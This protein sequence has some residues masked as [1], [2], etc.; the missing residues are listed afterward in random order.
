MKRTALVTGVLGGIGRATAKA[1]NEAGWHVIGVDRREDERLPY[2]D[3]YIQAD[4]ASPGEIA[5]AVECGGRAAGRLD[6]LVNMAA[7]QICKPAVQM[8]VEEWD[9]TMAVN[10]RAAF[11]FSKG[12]HP[13]L[14][15]SRGSIVNVSSVHAGAT[16]SDIACYAASKGALVALT[17]ALAIEFACDQI[18]VNAISPGA[19]DTPMLR[20]GLT[21]GHLAGASVED[22]IASLGKKTVMGRVGRPEEIA[23]SILFVAD[24]DRSSFMTGQVLV[25]DG[26]ATARLSTE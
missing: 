24:D 19:V 7:I 1:F 5:G 26:G 3:H 6:T 9:Q 11:L 21:R 12:A 15:E 25:I 16:S 4:A 13:L 20:A 23:Q 10:V 8:S 22:L 17:R 14:R 2:I 18:R